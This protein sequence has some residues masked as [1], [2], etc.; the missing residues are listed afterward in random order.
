ML[1]ERLIANG[2]FDAL[3]ERALRDVL[4]PPENLTQSRAVSRL[5]DLVLEI[6]PDICQ[7]CHGKRWIH[8]Y[9]EDP[10]CDENGRVECPVCDPGGAG[11]VKQLEYELREKL[12]DR[13]R[14][15][16]WLA[17]YE[18]EVVDIQEKLSKMKE[19][20]K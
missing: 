7:R 8:G 3:L 18:V 4:A 5:R 17:E 6:F 11:L 13:D 10:L 14:A 20:Q 16:D 12:I 15:R 2:T 9:P 1:L 19:K